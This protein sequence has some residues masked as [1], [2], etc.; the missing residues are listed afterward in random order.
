M[1]ELLFTDPHFKHRKLVEWGK[2]PDGFEMLIK[3]S[4]EQ[5]NSDDVIYCLGDVC[6]GDKVKA[7]EE[8][9]KPMPGYKILILGN[10]DKEKPQWYLEHGWDEV[11]HKLMLKRPWRVLLTHK[12]QVDDGS[13]DINIHGH[14]HNDSHRAKEPHYLAI[15]SPKHRLLALECVQYKLVSLQDFIDGKIEQ[16]GLPV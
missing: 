15:K 14:F 7:H 11:H 2:R 12:P 1:K 3:E 6:L 13:F 10:H 16:P 4:W 5:A 8:Y 9:V